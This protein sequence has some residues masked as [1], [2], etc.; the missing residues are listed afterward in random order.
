MRK[1]KDIIKEAAPISLSNIQKGMLIAAHVSATPQ[2]AFEVANGA[3][4]TMQAKVDLLSMG[5]IR[6]NNNAVIVTPAGNQALLNNNLVDQNGQI[7]EE[8]D[9]QLKSFENSKTQSI[10]LESYSILD[11]SYFLLN[12]L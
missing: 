7:T 12:S 5:L 10:N 8:G 6:Q 3:D 1:L 4:T 11:E 2:Q 9:Q